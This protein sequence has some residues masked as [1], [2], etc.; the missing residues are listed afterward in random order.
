MEYPFRGIFNLRLQ[1]LSVEVEDEGHDSGQRSL[2]VGSVRGHE[3]EQNRCHDMGGDAHEDN[4][5][6]T[7]LHR[8]ESIQQLQ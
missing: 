4:A 3:T 1:L 6:H 2:V 8:H 5:I 7:V